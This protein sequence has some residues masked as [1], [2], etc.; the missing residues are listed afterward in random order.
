MSSLSGFLLSD[1]VKEVILLV[2]EVVVGRG[3]DGVVPGRITVPVRSVLV[4]RVSN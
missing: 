1:G 3:V 4:G 2:M